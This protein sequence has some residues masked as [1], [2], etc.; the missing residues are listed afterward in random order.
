M[1]EIFLKSTKKCFALGNLG[2]WPN[3]KSISGVHYTMYNFI[4]LRMYYYDVIKF[5]TKKF[6][7]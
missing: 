4:V 2:I 6:N 5:H 1:N 3:V 7:F